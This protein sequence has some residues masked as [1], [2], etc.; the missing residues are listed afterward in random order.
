MSHN[1]QLACGVCKS[2]KKAMTKMLE[3]SISITE[4]SGRARAA[5]E[6]VNMGYHEEAKKLMTEKE[7]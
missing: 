4:S 6:L 5:S 2:L 3:L 1:T 7:L